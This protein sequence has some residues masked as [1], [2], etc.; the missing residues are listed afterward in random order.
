MA[1]TQQE[2][3]KKVAARNQIAVQNLPILLQEGLKFNPEM[4]L[5]VVVDRS[6][7]LA[8]LVVEKIDQSYAEFGNAT[9]LALP[10]R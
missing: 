4:S 7:V 1:L 8:D 3:L 9:E 2:K 5:Q 6:F 10:G